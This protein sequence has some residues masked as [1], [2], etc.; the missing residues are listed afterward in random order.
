MKRMDIKRFIQ[1]KYPNAEILLESEDILLFHV[2][3]FY[4][5]VKGDNLLIHNGNHF[6][7]PVPQKES[8]IECILDSLIVKKESGYSNEN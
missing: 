8:E 1:N 2:L 3:G 6:S 4:I 5:H 7:G